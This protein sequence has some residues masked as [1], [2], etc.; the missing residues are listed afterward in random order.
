MTRRYYP[1]RATLV[2]AGTPDRAGHRSYS[3][4]VPPALAETLPPGQ[5]FW[6]EA[7]E[8]GSLVFRPV[9]GPTAPTQAANGGPSVSENTSKKS[10]KSH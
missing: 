10:R 4:A 7:G 2:R 5:L 1:Q 8:G 3:I 9:G 6:A